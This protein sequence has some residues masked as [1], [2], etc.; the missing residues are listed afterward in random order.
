MNNAFGN[1]YVNGSIQRIRKRLTANPERSEAFKESV[2]DTVGAGMEDFERRL[3]TGQIQIDNVG[4]Y[5]KLVK[6]GLLVLGEATE[7]VEHT[8]DM[9]EVTVTQF[10]TI[11]DS[12]EYRAIKEKLSIEMNKQNEEA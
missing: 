1:N 3:R 6:L 2:I 5:E 9:E 10:E 12:D 8:T 11:K 7:K 4:D